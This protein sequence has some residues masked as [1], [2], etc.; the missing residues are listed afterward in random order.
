M[1]SP[2]L[3][4]APGPPSVALLELGYGVTYVVDLRVSELRMYRQRQ[5]FPARPLG[6]RKIA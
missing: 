6:L 5:D 1:A 2:I 3:R 4:Q